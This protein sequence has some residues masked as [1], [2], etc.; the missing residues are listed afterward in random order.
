MRNES[1]QQK[2]HFVVVGVGAYRVETFNSEVLSSTSELNIAPTAHSRKPLGIKTRK[3]VRSVFMNPLKQF[4]TILNEKR[5]KHAVSRLFE[6]S[7]HLIGQADTQALGCKFTISF[8]VLFL[9]EMWSGV[10]VS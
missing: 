6:K 10:A 9:G 5:Q 4:S 8:L 1:E 3:A 2:K 7:D